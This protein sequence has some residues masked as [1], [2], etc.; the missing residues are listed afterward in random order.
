MLPFQDSLSQR[1][2]PPW[3]QKHQ[4]TQLGS[5][6]TEPDHRLQGSAHLAIEQKGQK[7]PTTG[8][9][10]QPN[11][12]EGQ[13]DGRR[14]DVSVVGR[15]R[16]NKHWKPQQRKKKNGV[17]QRSQSWPRRRAGSPPGTAQQPHH[18]IHVGCSDGPCTQHTRCTVWLGDTA[19][20]PSTGIETAA[21][22]RFRHG[23]KLPG[24][25][26]FLALLYV[27]GTLQTNEPDPSAT[28][29]GTLLELEPTAQGSARRSDIAI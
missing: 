22:L 14:L 17:G 15:W 5:W 19:G 6:V 10:V 3:I 25:F 12:E 16:S 2:E 13:T 11:W 4:V 23:Y 7:N 24:I 29:P 26:T 28:I 18:H 8:L 1:Q 21:N 27:Q 9:C 20:F